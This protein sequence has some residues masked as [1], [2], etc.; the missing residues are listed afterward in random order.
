MTRVLWRQ[1]S[2]SQCVVSESNLQ[3]KATAMQEDAG[4]QFPASPFAQGMA[5]VDSRR[6]YWYSLDD[7]GFYDSS[8]DNVNK[9]AAA[10]CAA[11]Q[12]ARRAAIAACRAECLPHRM[13]CEIEE[14]IASL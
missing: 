7:V 12:R 10:L 2:V 9:I 3:I 6:V 5:L 14:A 11:E 1:I 4:W 8:H 13:A